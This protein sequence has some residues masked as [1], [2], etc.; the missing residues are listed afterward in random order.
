MSPLTNP[1]RFTGRLGRRPEILHK[2]TVVQFYGPGPRPC[3]DCAW[4][5]QQR[6]G[7]PSPDHACGPDSARGAPRVACARR[8]AWFT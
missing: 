5:S 6:A 7:F 4:T 1:G 2:R 8:A 3:F